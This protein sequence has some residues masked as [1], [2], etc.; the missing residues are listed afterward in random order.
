MNPQ[1][2]APL[3]VA[4]AGFLAVFVWRV[5]PLWPWRAENRELAHALRE[6]RTRITAA[7][8]GAERAKALC[9]AADLVG[10]RA[11]VVGGWSRAAALFGRALRTDPRS[12]AVV[13]RSIAGLSE[14]PRELESLLWRHLSLTPWAEAPDAVRA[15]LCALRTIY[16]GPI[17]RT[18][19]AKALERAEEILRVHTE[20]KTGSVG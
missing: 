17:R 3:V 19:R 14:R 16:E 9:D 2:T 13:T 18:A 1:A 15:S 12:L 10:R 20:E 8:D 11:A 5:R 4:A 7:T 6:V